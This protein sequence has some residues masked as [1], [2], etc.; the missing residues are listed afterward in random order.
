MILDS[1]L[2]FADAVA[3]NTGVAGTYLVGSQ[4]DL[5]AAPAAPGP[6]AGAADGLYLVITVDTAFVSG[7]GGSAA[8]IL[9]SDASASIATDGSATNHFQTKAYTAAQGAA[10]AVLAIVELPKHLVYERYLGILQVTTTAAFSAGKINAFLT[11][12][13]SDWVAYDAPQQA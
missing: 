4:I 12:D 11:T 8:F 2:E 3:L 9:A 10:G 1:L 13:P 6:R 7:G 5:G